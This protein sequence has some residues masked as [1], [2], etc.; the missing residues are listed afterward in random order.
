MLAH[1]KIKNLQKNI[2]LNS[3]EIKKINYLLQMYP[4]LKIMRNGFF[5]SAKINKDYNQT[6]FYMDSYKLSITRYKEIY[7]PSDE[8]DFLIKVYSSPLSNNILTKEFNFDKT[9]S[10]PHNFTIQFTKFCKNILTKNFNKEILNTTRQYIFDFLDR[11]PTCN[12]N[13]KNLDE[14]TRKLLSYR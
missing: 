3:F 11:H 6:T 13:S 8:M 10:N 1:E 14:G 7:M 5:A 2:N 9:L 12:I 4:D